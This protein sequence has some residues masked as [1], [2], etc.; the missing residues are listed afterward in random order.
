MTTDSKRN[1]NLLTIF[2]PLWA[3]SKIFASLRQILKLSTRSSSTHTAMASWGRLG[4]WWL[5]VTNMVGGVEKRWNEIL[6]EVKI[7]KLSEWVSEWPNE[8]I[9]EKKMTNNG[10]LNE[11]V[12]GLEM[13]FNLQTFWDCNRSFEKL[14]KH[15]GW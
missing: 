6:R 11:C 13:L 4:N 5:A 1:S 15:L 8:Q 10:I 14:T 2:M 12:L 9:S 3:P 7:S